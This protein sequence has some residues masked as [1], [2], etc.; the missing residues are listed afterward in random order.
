MSY[1]PREFDRVVIL[2][3]GEPGVV[4]FKHRMQEGLQGFEVELDTARDNT[5]V[6]TCFS[7]ELGP[8]IRNRRPLEKEIHPRD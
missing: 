1:Y 6:V 8:L 3:T 7:Q 2:E 5:R 4:V